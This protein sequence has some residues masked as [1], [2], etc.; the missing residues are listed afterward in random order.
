VLKININYTVGNY[1]SRKYLLIIIIVKMLSM[2]YIVKPL[3]F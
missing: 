3:F 1:P 2:G